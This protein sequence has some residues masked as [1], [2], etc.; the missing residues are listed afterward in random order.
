[1]VLTYQGATLIGRT[2]PN[3]HG[4]IRVPRDYALVLVHRQAL[5]VGLQDK[6]PWENAERQ[7]RTR[8]P[9]LAENTWVRG[10]LSNT[11]LRDGAVIAQCSGLPEPSLFL[12][13]TLRRE[14]DTVNVALTLSSVERASVLAMLGAYEGSLRVARR[15]QESL[16]TSVPPR[17]TRGSTVPTE[18]LK[19]TL[20]LQQQ[21]GITVHF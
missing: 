17:A 19:N 14:R 16:M 3:C 15:K 8:E 4:I 12:P 11:D 6:V 21:T 1:M 18:S 2:M 13:C 20:A 5:V 10:L 7:L 9:R